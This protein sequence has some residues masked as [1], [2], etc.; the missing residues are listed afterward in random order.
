MYARIYVYLDISKE[1]PESIKLSWH[2]EEWLQAIDYEHIPFC[3]HKCHEYGH[4]FRQC[5]LNT[6]SLGPQPKNGEKDVEG[7]EKVSNR[8]RMTKRNLSL[9]GHKKPQTSNRFET[10]REDTEEDEGRVET[11]DPIAQ[12]IDKE[13][14]EEVPR[15]S[16]AME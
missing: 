15:H 8:M 6:S 9:D 4:L 10:L 2:D 16:E 14:I 7:F 13:T 1:L 11:R 12:S 3:C 5:P